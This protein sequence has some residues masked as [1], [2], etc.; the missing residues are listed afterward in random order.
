VLLRA[1]VPIDGVDVMA[2]RRGGRRDL[3]DGPA[4]LCQAFAIGPEHNS[5]D[6]CGGGDIGLFDDG[7][8]PPNTPRVGPRIGI[9]KAV[10]VPWRFRV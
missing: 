8:P 3:T 6:L 2:E 7:T 5:V 9:T 4:K 10:E 1:L